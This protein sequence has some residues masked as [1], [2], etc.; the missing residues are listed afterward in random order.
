MLDGVGEVGVDAIET[1][2]R[3]ADRLAVS[4]RALAAERA[5]RLRTLVAANPRALEMT[6][7]GPAVRGEVIAIDPSPETVEAVRRAGFAVVADEEIEGLG[8]RSVTLK[9]PDGMPLRRA[10]ALLRTMAPQG[11]FTAN[12]LHLPS[13]A[14]APA[15]P[16]AAGAALAL[17]G[18]G[19]GPAIGI[20]DGGVAAHPALAGPIEQRGFARGAPAPSAHGT[21][22]A[23]LAAGRGAIRGAAPGTRLLVADVYGR[24]PAGGNARSLA[25]ALGWMTQRQVPVVAVSLVG[26][27]NA[28]VRR[29]IS[30]ARARG[31]HVVAAVGND[32]AAAPPA[33]PASYP[34]VVAVTGVD[35]R[36][37]ALL[38]AGR[39]LH[40]DY[41]APGADL[42]AATLSG[43]TR[44]VRGTSFAVPF[45][46]ARI[47]R[48][49]AAGRRP[50]PALDAEAIDLPPRGPDRRH[51]RGLVCGDCRTRPG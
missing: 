36:N 23:S 5:N 7:G 14:P 9:A 29:A 8:I 31:V 43:G 30:Q 10:L 45:V 4:A 48:A 34:G 17:Q 44:A 21:A 15:M 49:L 28:L 22:V 40:L 26:P 20:I 24:D 42:A 32:G 1:A 19:D 25:Q 6:D 37:R 18:G 47:S 46:A 38:E 12:H 11:E 51:G 16:F 27:D 2:T 41:A 50:I 13:E 3:T 35:G 33:Y 39:A